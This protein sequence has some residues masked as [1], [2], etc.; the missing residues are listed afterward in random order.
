MSE[1]GPKPH[2]VKEIRETRGKEC[3]F[4]PGAVVLVG[5]KGYSRA[6]V[7]E[8]FTA[9]R[10]VQE[11]HDERSMGYYQAT[12]RGSTR[13]IASQKPWFLNPGDCFF[14]YLTPAGRNVPPKK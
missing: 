11:P 7:T 12:S 9:I 4:Y 6:A 2:G 14:G 10:L 3:T 5:N 1:R 8:Q 13:F